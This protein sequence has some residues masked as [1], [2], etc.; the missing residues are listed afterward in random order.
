MTPV[1][2]LFK[3][4]SAF[5]YWLKVTHKL[6]SHINFDKWHN[7]HEIQYNKDKSI[8]IYTKDDKTIDANSLPNNLLFRFI[9]L[10]LEYHMGVTHLLSKSCFSRE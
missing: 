7:G 6:V 9:F 1:A 4:R 3:W 10:Y 5:I 2:N 8:S